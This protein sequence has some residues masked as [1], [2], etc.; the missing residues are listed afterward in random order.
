MVN[1]RSS[2][3]KDKTPNSFGPAAVLLKVLKKWLAKESV[4]QGLKPHCE[5]CTCG[6]AKAVPLSKTNG[7][8]A[9]RRHL[10]RLGSPPFSNQNC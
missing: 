1:I 10:V 5:Q 3:S 4:P 2:V 6:T 8:S 9:H 7:L